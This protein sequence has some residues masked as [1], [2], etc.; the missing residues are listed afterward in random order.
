[1]S[2]FSTL[3]LLFNACN[4]T[5]KTN[6]SDNKP[7][8]IDTTP[9]VDPYKAQE[10]KVGNNIIE[11]KSLHNWEYSEE[12]TQKVKSNDPRSLEMIAYKSNYSDKSNVGFIYQ[13][14]KVDGNLDGAIDGT[15]RGY[16]IDPSTEIKDK[17]ITDVSEKFGMPAKIVTGRLV[18]LKYKGN[19]Q[20]QFKFLTIANGKEMFF[21]QGIFP[22]VDGF[23]SKDFDKI[24]NSITI[25]K[26]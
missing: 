7:S 1:M 26:K 19:Q 10:I 22:E 3:L 21:F 9:K 13:R 6:V 14:A 18:N 20:V 5:K 11:F 16:Q 24:L 2:I 23:N 8:T 15:L 25:N 12:M 17:I 4:E